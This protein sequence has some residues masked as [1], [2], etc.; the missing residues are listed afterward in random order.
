MSFNFDE[1]LRELKNEI[2]ENAITT[3]KFKQIIEEYKRLGFEIQKVLEYGVRSIKGDE[4]EKIDKI[5]KQFLSIN[6]GEMADKLRNLGYSLKN[7]QD[8]EKIRSAL[9]AQAFRILER[10]RHAHRSEVFYM[11]A[12]IFTVNSKEFPSLLA[13]AFNPNYSDEL[14]KVYI[15]SFLSGILGEKENKQGGVV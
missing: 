3:E 2:K 1:K 13:Q 14:F 7:N 9:S 11:I 12:R 4:K 10:V 8:Y 6:S 5:Y 15:Y